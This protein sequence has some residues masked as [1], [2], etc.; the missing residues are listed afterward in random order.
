[1]KPHDI[2]LLLFRAAH[3]AELVASFRRDGCLAS[4]FK[5]F[6][7][8]FDGVDPEKESIPTIQNRRVVEANRFRRQS[9]RIAEPKSKFVLNFYV[10]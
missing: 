3:A 6:Y 1:M 9:R 2:L 10:E 7:L 8:V 4:N 5:S